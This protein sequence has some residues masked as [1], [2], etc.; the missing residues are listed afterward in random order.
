MSRRWSERSRGLLGLLACLV[1]AVVITV[2]VP[3]PATDIRRRFAD[4]PV[5]D[6]AST[7]FVRARVTQ[8]EVTRSVQGDYGD[9]WVSDQTLVVASVEAQVRQRVT[10]FSEVVLRT[11][12]GHDYEPRTEFISAALGQ[13]QPGFTRHAVLVFELPPDRV[14]GAELVIDADGASFDFYAAAI[15]IDLGLQDPVTA[16]AGPLTVLPSSVSTT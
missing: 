14:P 5:G 9:P 12:D 2:A 11:R 15:R 3:D 10:Q 7:A 1:L 6:F 8:V 16:S 13:T 4:A